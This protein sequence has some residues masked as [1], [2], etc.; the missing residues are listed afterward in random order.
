MYHARRLNA[1]PVVALDV[2]SGSKCEELNESKSSRSATERTSMRRPRHFADGPTALSRVGREPT[3]EP[4]DIR[5]RFPRQS[6]HHLELGNQAAR[7]RYTRGDLKTDLPDI[8]KSPCAS[9]R[10]AFSLAGHLSLAADA[11]R[12]ARPDEVLDDG[13]DSLRRKLADDLLPWRFAI[14]YGLCNLVP[15][16]QHHRHASVINIAGIALMIAAATLMSSTSKLDRP[17]PKLF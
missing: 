13:G 8:Q 3:P 6:H 9:S 15:I 16:F 5:T 4:R 2:R 10:S 17:G 14:V 1:R 12:L 11:A 7:G